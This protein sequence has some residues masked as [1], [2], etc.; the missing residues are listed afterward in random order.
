MNLRKAV[1]NIKRAGLVALITNANAFVTV[2]MEKHVSQYDK[3]TA[4]A[5]NALS[6][7]PLLYD[8]GFSLGHKLF[9]DDQNFI[10]TAESMTGT[11]NQIPRPYLGISNRS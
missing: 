10:T 3:R 8:I 2:G 11:K 7:V 4:A 1:S 6:A 9:Y 5:I